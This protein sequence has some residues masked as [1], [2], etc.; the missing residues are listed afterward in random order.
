[1]PIGVDLSDGGA[2]TT[3]E[4]DK[5]ST[6]QTTDTGKTT[7]TVTS[8]DKS[9]GSTG[10]PTD[11]TTA[12][13]GN[14]TPWYDSFTDTAL[15]EF[16]KSK[17]WADPEAQIKSHMELDKAFSSTRPAAPPADAKDYKFSDV[18]LPDGFNLPETFD[19]D[20]RGLLHKAGIDNDRGDKLRGAY[21]EYA[22]AQRQAAV[23]AQQRQLHESVEAAHNDLEAAF[24]AKA[25][26][27]LFNRQVEMAKRAMKMLD[28]GLG[29]A[30]KQIGVIAD[31]DGKSMVA[32]ATVFAALAKVGS[33]LYAE[34]TLHGDPA[35][36]ANP[37]DPKTIDHNAQAKLMRND[38]ERAK[39]L[40]RALAP[41]DQAMWQTYLN[42]K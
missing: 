33:E 28:P 25:G 36:G 31:V 12:T 37:F 6:T 2:P 27:P 42:K 41:A 23:E 15:K 38:P 4:G 3:G 34:D 40:I 21:L 10:S 29:D 32:N 1:M 30:L 24:K 7:S 17:G 22:A 9:G 19:Q 14:G 11:K 18:K 13:G 39:M 35:S 8:G 16:A 20:I 26:S 5:S